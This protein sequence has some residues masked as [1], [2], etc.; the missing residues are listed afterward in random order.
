MTDITV[1]VSKK[2]TVFPN[3]ATVLP[4]KATVLTKKVTVLPKKSTSPKEGD[5]SPKEGDC[6]PKEVDFS[7]RRG[8]FSQRR[9]LVLITHTCEHGAIDTDTSLDSVQDLPVAWGSVRPWSLDNNRLNYWS[10]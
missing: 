1:L 7:Q 9:G 3:N 2:S 10:K 4:K 8:L 5:C 6:S